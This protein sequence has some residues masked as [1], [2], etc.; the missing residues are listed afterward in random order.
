MQSKLY[1]HADEIY[2]ILTLHT[3][4][5]WYFLPWAFVRMLSGRLFYLKQVFVLIENHCQAKSNLKCIHN[6]MIHHY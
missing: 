4:H 2:K 5:V 1:D 6:G 3:S